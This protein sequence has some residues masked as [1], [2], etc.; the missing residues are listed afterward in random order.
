MNRKLIAL[1]AIL[2]CAALT[3]SGWAQ[4]SETPNYVQIKKQISNSNSLQYYPK[5]IE[6]FQQCDTMLTNED[7][8]LLYYGFVTREDFVPYGEKP[9]RFYDIRKHFTNTNVERP[10]LEEAINITSEVLENNPFDIAAIGLRATAYLLMNDS[11]NYLL[12]KAK[13]EGLLE[14]ISSSGDGETAETAF[15]VIDIAH[16]YEITNHLGLTVL[17]DSLINSGVEYLRVG[18]NADNIPGIFFNF[19]ECGNIYHR[20]YE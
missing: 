11:T 9:Q 20:K 14:A 12:N 17:K 10:A 15:H 16:E 6:R 7:Y 3:Q 2:L 4:E 18:E 1:F 13:Y 8:R 19:K 5:L